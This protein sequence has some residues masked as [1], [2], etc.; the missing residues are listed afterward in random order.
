[1]NGNQ[2]TVVIEHVKWFLLRFSD[3]HY[4]IHSILDVLIVPSLILMKSTD[5]EKHLSPNSRQRNNDDGD[6]ERFTRWHNRSGDL[7]TVKDFLRFRWS[8]FEVRGWIHKTN[9]RSEYFSLHREKVLWPVAVGLRDVF[10][11]DSSERNKRHSPCRWTDI[12]LMVSEEE[13]LG[14]HHRIEVKAL[15]LI[16]WQRDCFHSS[17]EICRK[18]VNS[19]DRNRTKDMEKV[20]TTDERTIIEETSVSRHPRFHASSRQREDNEQDYKQLGLK[21][22]SMISEEIEFE[23]RWTDLSRFVGGQL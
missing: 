4:Q 5:W 10:L 19:F 16:L 22:G 15:S 23:W 14:D 9:R 17:H 21:C 3:I 2:F 18:F 12:L 13:E 20:W 1:M 7:R 6:R 8:P 11:V